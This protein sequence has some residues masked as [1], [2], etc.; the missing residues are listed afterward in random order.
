LLYSTRSQ[1]GLTDVV[2]RLC[3]RRPTCLLNYY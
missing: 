1:K 3:H 2:T